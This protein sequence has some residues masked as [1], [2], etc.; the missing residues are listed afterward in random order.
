MIVVHMKGPVLGAASSWWTFTDSTD[1]TLG[2]QDRIVFF[3]A[4][5]VE[6]LEIILP[7]VHPLR[8]SAVRVGQTPRRHTIDGLLRIGY[9]S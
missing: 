3:E 2:R 8:L 6:L 4:H 9:V 7:I 1:A 5:P